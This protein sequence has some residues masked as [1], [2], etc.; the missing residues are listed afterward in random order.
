MSYNKTI[1]LA[2][3][4]RATV[5]VE[6]E[7][8]IVPGMPTRRWDVDPGYPAEVDGMTYEVTE[9][10]F[11]SGSIIDFSWMK[12]RGFLPVVEGLIDPNDIEEKLGNLDCYLND[13]FNG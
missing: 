2:L 3:S 5:E 9:V 4:E 1:K 11:H 12:Q 8:D 7:F 10:K 6:T 13:T